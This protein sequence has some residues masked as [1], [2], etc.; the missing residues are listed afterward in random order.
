MIFTVNL[1]QM[2]NY[3]SLFFVL[4]FSLVLG[5]GSFQSQL[6]DFI[7]PNTKL[8]AYQVL[9]LQLESLKNNKRLRQDRGIKQVYIFAHPENKK[10]TGPID[11]FTKM[12]KSDAYSMFLDHDD[13]KVAVMHQ[14]QFHE[15]YLIRVYKGKKSRDFV[16]TLI[17]Y[18][19]NNKIPYWYTVN[20]IPVDT[21]T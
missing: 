14:D 5:F 18:I 16:W 3:K 15:I 12:L 17:T 2:K 1:R 10:V 9:A 13:S 8:T 7:K 20:V 4:A 21:K 19:D 11:N 6:K